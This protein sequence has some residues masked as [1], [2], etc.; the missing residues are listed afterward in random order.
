MTRKR[1]RERGDSR[2]AISGGRLEHGCVVLP[3]RVFRTSCAAR[4][5]DRLS[6][7]APG[8]DRIW[9]VASGLLATSRGRV[10]VWR[11][12]FEIVGVYLYD[13]H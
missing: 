11:E 1:E 9:V 6:A 2:A 7:H 8:N 12:A 13:T 5:M 3:V 10:G 4:E